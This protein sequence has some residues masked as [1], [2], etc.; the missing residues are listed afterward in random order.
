M[1]WISLS[2][3]L[4]PFGIAACV[5]LIKVG[6]W[7]QTANHNSSLGL[8]RLDILKDAMLVTGTINREDIRGWDNED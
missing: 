2:A 3:V 7:A 6:Q 1:D 4:S 8:K 5:W